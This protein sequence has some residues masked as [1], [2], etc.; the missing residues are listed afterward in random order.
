M[1]LKHSPKVAFHQASRADCL[2][3][4]YSGPQGVRVLKL[5]RRQLEA[6]CKPRFGDYWLEVGPLGLLRPEWSGA[7]QTLHT[8]PD[9][10]TLRALAGFLPL[11]EQ[12]F[13]CVLLAHALGDANDSEAIIAEAQRVMAPE[14]Y[15]FVLEA[16]HC[17]VPGRRRGR[18]V[19][20]LG[21]RRRR[22][23]RLLESAGLGV[24]RQ[25][26]LTVLPAALPRDWHRRL[27]RF[28]AAVSPW[29]PMMGSC[30]L[31]VARRRDLIPIAPVAAR[32]RWSRGAV[33]AGGTSQWA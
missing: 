8:D 3:R 23:R 12:T 18:S 5:L 30:V 27:D 7:A 21:L 31:T 19:V 1:D 11:A 2:R 22:M 6:F 4:W 17:N 15:L 29:L 14:G 32:P 16:G 28:D 24:R 9:S 26:A 33:R 10:Q 13:S 20:P 25:I